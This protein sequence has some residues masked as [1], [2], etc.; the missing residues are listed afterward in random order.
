[1]FH[2]NCP[3]LA[4]SL[5]HSEMSVE[6]RQFEP[7]LHLYGAP[8]GSNAVGLSRKFWALKTRVPELSYCVV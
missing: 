2:S 7:T 3:Y 8:V 6:N 4:P 5:R 1:M